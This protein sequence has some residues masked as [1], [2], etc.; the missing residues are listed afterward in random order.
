MEYTPYNEEE[1]MDAKKFQIEFYEKQNGEIP[2]ETFLLNQDKKMRAKLVGLM[3]ILQEYANRLRAPYSKH[4]EDGIF[5]LRGQTGNNI[6][7]I[8]YFFYFEG[9]IIVTNGFVKKT[10]KTPVSEIETAKKFR[11]D[12]LERRDCNEK[13]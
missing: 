8:L 13:V 2:V 3:E 1:E 4:L 6:A 7:R 5:E 11:R 10:Q 9:K 12:Y